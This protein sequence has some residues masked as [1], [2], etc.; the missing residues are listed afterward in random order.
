MSD[1]TIRCRSSFDRFSQRFT[2]NFLSVFG[3]WCTA[4]YRLFERWATT[5]MI[6]CQSLIPVVGLILSLFQL[7]MSV[8]G[9]IIALQIK[10]WKQVEVSPCHW[11]SVLIL[12]QVRVRTSYD[13]FRSL[14][15]SC[16]CGGEIA[17][18]RHVASATAVSASHAK[19]NPS[20]KVP[21]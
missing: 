12:I 17:I 20:F 6:L 2:V 11:L 5:W 21:V 3:T 8:I 7:L 15:L 13:R 14:K 19:V 16:G 10:P 4:K 9:T 1:R 18:N